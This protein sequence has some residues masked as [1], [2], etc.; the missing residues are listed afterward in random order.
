MTLHP[1]GQF[2]LNPLFVQCGK[3]GASAIMPNSSL[4]HSSQTP[5]MLEFFGKLL[6]SFFITSDLLAV[7]FPPLF[8][9]LLLNES[10]SLRDMAVFDVSLVDD[11]KPSELMA[12]SAEEL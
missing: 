11:V 8:W 5:M 9:K 10:T 6:A 12:R 4:L 2:Q 3:S 1:S 7:A